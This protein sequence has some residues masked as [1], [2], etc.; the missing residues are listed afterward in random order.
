MRSF[1]EPCQ[2][3]RQRDSKSNGNPLLLGRIARPKA[4]I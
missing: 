4:F 2:G 3:W 1:D